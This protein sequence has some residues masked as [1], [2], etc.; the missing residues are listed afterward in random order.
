MK[1]VV[2]LNADLGESYGVYS[3]GADEEL[4]RLITS[5]NIACGYHASDPTVMHS[6]VKTA[7]QNGVA[8]GAHPSYPDR[9]GFGR[10]FMELS[11]S[12]LYACLIYQLGALNGFCRLEG[13][14]M[15]Y[16]KPHGALYNAASADG[17]IAYTVA[18]AI[19]DY[20]SELVLLC[21]AGSKLQIEAKRN[22]LKT[23]GEFFADR[24]YD[25]SG[26]LVSRR[27]PNAVITDAN[28]VV[29][30]VIEA[31]VNKRVIAIDGTPLELEFDSICLHG[32][33]PRAVE[34][35]KSIRRA[36]EEN[37]IELKAFC[38]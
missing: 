5:A 18:R 36:L 10:R 4:M 32:D 12:E 9:Q 3:Y 22:G 17:D 37:G 26:A 11:P 7:R 16:C 27:L 6:A 20:C 29:Q 15:S 1:R 35:A 34:L 25:K 19:R 24:A 23:A 13:C 2:D 21:P 28:A 38:K 33:N 30:R 14:K 8:I 31:V